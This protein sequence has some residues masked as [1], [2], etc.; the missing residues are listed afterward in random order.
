MAVS[1]YDQ[2]RALFART[3][4]QELKAIERALTF[5]PWNNSLRENVRLMAVRDLLA[6]KKA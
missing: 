2:E 1:L 4:R 3:S 6:E 5:H